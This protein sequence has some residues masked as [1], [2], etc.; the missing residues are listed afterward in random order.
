MYIRTW[1]SPGSRKLRV[2]TNQCTRSLPVI[3]YRL[4]RR[5]F[6]LMA[7]WR[8]EGPSGLRGT[9][10]INGRK[11]TLKKSS[12]RTSGIGK[13]ETSTWRKFWKGPKNSMSKEWRWSRNQSLIVGTST[14]S[15]TK[16]RAKQQR[17]KWT[18]QLMSEYQHH[19]FERR[20]EGTRQSVASTKGAR[21]KPGKS[22]TTSKLSIRFLTSSKTREKTTDYQVTS[23]EWACLVINQ[24]SVW[25]WSAASVRRMHWCQVLPVKDSSRIHSTRM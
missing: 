13:S 22:G 10:R 18:R 11:C 4:S 15:E 16:G 2:G 19:F 17:L 25:R 8:G 3:L 9:R 1:H 5:P 23:K 14:E 6:R 24:H 21:V 12:S 20:Q 7:H